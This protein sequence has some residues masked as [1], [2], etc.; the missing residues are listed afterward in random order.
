MKRS[1]KNIALILALLMLV[2]SISA[3]KG[4][5]TPANP[6]PAQPG[7]TSTQPAQPAPATGGGSDTIGNIGTVETNPEDRV[8]SDETLRV[9]LDEEPNVL[10]PQYSSPSSPGMT[11]GTAIFDSLFR[12][13]SETKH[14]DPC[15]ATD[16]EWIDTTHLR[17]FLRRGVIGHDGKEM[18]ADDVLFT[19]EFGTSGTNTNYT[20]LFVLD[21]CK[22]EDDYTFVLALPNPYPNMV[23]ILCS[24]GYGIISRSATEAVGG[25][26]AGTR[27]TKI[28]FGRYTYDSWVSGQYIRLAR[29]DAYWDT[30]KVPYYK[31]VDFTWNGDTATRS[32]AIQSGDADVT[33]NL[34]AT[35]L[36]NM[37]TMDGISVYGGPSD[38]GLSLWM[39]CKN[40][41][42]SD[43]RVR[44]AISLLV[45]RDAVVNL[46]YGGYTLPTDT[47]V[48]QLSKYYSAPAQWPKRDAERAK[49]L[50]AEAGYAG[51]LTFNCMIVAKNSNLAE[52]LQSN[53]AEGGIDLDISPVE[54]PVM[55]GTLMGGEY[56]MYL[57]DLPG[58]DP[59]RLLIRIDGRLPIPAAAGGAQYNDDALNA[60]IDTALYN[61]DEATRVA[62]YADIQN[63]VRQNHV[64]VGICSEICS[65]A[66]SS[67]LTGIGFC[68]SFF[69][70][71]SNVRPIGK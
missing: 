15:L 54:F 35:Q 63:Y 11:I 21:E 49:A 24:E 38:S 9:V 61:P 8:M 52:L 29:H 23:D 20:R 4:D 62:A 32:M 3:C 59:A 42:L 10:T 46:I 57:T 34:T 1:V 50:L 69:P 12:W 28:G 16:Y 17:L 58:N 64:Q 44:E 39:N 26:E 45:D 60:F 41:A 18:T 22:V 7:Q 14:A 56:E 36:N 31:Y 13:N 33:F 48:T 40:E 27:T 67:D 2:V 5:E 47:L 71:I 66:F 37:S 70:D 53:L 25:I 65:A 51:G 55:M 68:P 19:I 6:P 30:D 43:Q